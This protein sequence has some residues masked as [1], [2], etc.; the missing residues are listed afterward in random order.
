MNRLR[1]SDSE[2]DIPIKYRRAVEVIDG[3]FGRWITVFMW[4]GIGV[5][6]LENSLQ[7][8]MEWIAVSMGCGSLL[9]GIHV[10]K[11]KAGEIRNLQKS[12]ERI[13]SLRKA[14]DDLFGSRSDS[15]LP[16]RDNYSTRSD[17]MAHQPFEPQGY[18]DSR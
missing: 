5:G 10:F 17:D 7:V 16:I 8:S 9:G 15:D 11:M 12:E 14:E 2:L 6:A 1:G 18:K 3:P 4:I 13:Q